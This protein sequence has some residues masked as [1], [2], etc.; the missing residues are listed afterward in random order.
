[1]SGVLQLL[2]LAALA[3]LA[4]FFLDRGGRSGYGWVTGSEFVLA[5]LVVGPAGLD[6]F[7]ADLIDSAR[8]VL[9]LGVVWIGFRF[10]LRLRP[11]EVRAHSWRLLLASQIEP[12]VALFA[13]GGGLILAAWALGAPLAWV[14]AWALAASGSATTK[15]ALIWAKSRHGAK[16]TLTEALDAV[17]AFDDSI[18]L[19]GA[20]AVF[21]LAHPGW[22]H[23]FRWMTMLPQFG[24]PLIATVVLGVGLGV[25]VLL[26]TGRGV[27]RA[28][29]AWIALFGACAL[30]SGLSS[31]LGLSAMAAASLAGATVGWFS[32]HAD[33]LE[34]ITR[35]TER[36]LV[37][38]LLVLGGASARADATPW[39]WALAFVGFRL[40]AKL[41]GGAAASPLVLVNKKPAWQMGAGLFAGGGVGFA[42]CFG[43][44]LTLP[45]ADAN[46]LISGA[47]AM[48]V[49][50]DLLGSPVLKALLRSRGELHPTTGA[51]AMVEPHKAPS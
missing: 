6:L 33:H 26:I 39:L 21:A 14:T 18:G 16:G 35:P 34:E 15:S 50:G 11:A 47:C 45:Q 20:A 49:V 32:P 31:Q 4:T 29:L 22:E 19:A 23:G 1:M 2:I 9:V 42:L 13:I 43:L 44:A 24:G 46:T 48:A 38:M 30:D 28:D 5:G 17:T 10:G 37:Q 41:L 51:H 8:P 7:S 27:F 36:P 40:V 25:V 12:L 3:Y